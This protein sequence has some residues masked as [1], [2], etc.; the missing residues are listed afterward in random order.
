MTLAAFSE[1]FA[2]LQQR[3]DQPDWLT[4]QRQQAFSIFTDS[5]LPTPR[6]ENWK[7]TDLRVLNRQNF[8][9]ANNP[10]TNCDELLQQSRIDGLDCYELVFL[11]G[12]FQKDLSS[13]SQQQGIVITSLSQAMSSSDDSLSHLFDATIDEPTSS[14][15]TLNSALAVDGAVIRLYANQVLDKPLHLIFINSA[16]EQSIGSHF[17]ILI[18]ADANSQATIL[19]SY[20]GKNETSYLTNTVTEISAA[21]GANIEHYKLQQ[22]GELAYHISN[23]YIQQ[24]RDS[25]VLTHTVNLGARLNRNDVRVQLNDKGANIQMYGLTLGHDRQHIDDHTHVN[26]NAAH[27]VS[28]ESYKSILTDFS[29]GVFNGKVVVKADAQKIESSQSS[30]NLLLSEK[31]EMDTKPELEIYADDVKCAHGA[32]VGQL[33][34]NQ[35]FYLR[36]RGIDEEHARSLLTYAFADDI[37]SQMSVAAVRQ[38]IERHIVGRLPSDLALEGLL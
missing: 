33:D 6:Q 10:E 3:T 26:H 17:R 14:F 38:H 16:P 7:Y 37:I 27:T 34:E 24:S 31:C 28:H 20:A 21:D 18:Q 25:H 9:A 36:S 35:L 13:V 23:L 2:A 15:V 11:D 8:G 5:G 22:E 19:E 29:R 30:R 4:K 32:T 1:N 12:S